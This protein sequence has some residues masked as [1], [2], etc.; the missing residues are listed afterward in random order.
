MNKT[1]KKK[2]KTYKAQWENKQRAVQG[3]EWSIEDKA[4]MMR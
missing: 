2:N 1:N 3:F 4:D